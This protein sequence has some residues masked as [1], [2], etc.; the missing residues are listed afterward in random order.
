MRSLVGPGVISSGVDVFQGHQHDP[1]STQ[2]AGHLARPT[3]P[4]FLEGYDTSPEGPVKITTRVAARHS[5]ATAG[6]S[7]TPADGPCLRHLSHATARASPRHEPERSR[8]RRPGR[9]PSALRTRSPTGRREENRAHHR[10]A[11][12]GHPFS[13]RATPR[14]PARP[15]A[16]TP[17]SNTRHSDRRGTTKTRARPEPKITKDKQTRARPQKDNPPNQAQGG[18]STHSNRKGSR[19]CHFGSQSPVKSG[20]VAL[21][22]RAITREGRSLPAPVPDATPNPAQQRETRT[23]V[24]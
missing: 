24:P 23:I 16:P 21:P 11:R 1:P 5:G 17:T 13:C 7:G 3:R 18:V 2:D 20:E 9:R 22:E 10:D 15:L 14:N 6:V 12:P 19:L 4:P 8:P